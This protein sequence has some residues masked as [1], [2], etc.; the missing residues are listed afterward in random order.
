MSVSVGIHDGRTK[1]IDSFLDLKKSVC[2]GTKDAEQTLQI[3]D[4]IFQGREFNDKLNEYLEE[5]KNFS[6]CRYVI[7]TL[8]ERIFYSGSEEV[9]KQLYW[10]IETAPV[11]SE[12][13]E[14]LL[15]AL[16]DALMQKAEEIGTGELREELAAK[17]PK[18]VI[19][20]N[21]LELQEDF[22]FDFFAPVLELD[23]DEINVFLVRVLK[24][25]QLCG[26]VPRE[27]LLELAVKVSQ[28]LHVSETAEVLFELKKYYSSI[29][30]KA[31]EEELPADNGTRYIA[32]KT[33]AGIQELSAKGSEFKISD[34]P[35]IQRIIQWYK[36]L[37]R[38]SRRDREKAY[39]T[40]FSRMFGVYR[41]EIKDYRKLLKAEEIKVK[42][43]ESLSIPITIQY[44]KARTRDETKIKKETEFYGKRCRFLIPKDIELPQEDY[45]QIYIHVLPLPEN[46]KYPK[47]KSKW[48]PKEAELQ[49]VSGNT[50]RDG[51]PV[52]K[53]VH[54]ANIKDIA[55]NLNSQKWTRP[56]WFADPEGKG[57]VVLDILYGEKLPEGLCFE[58]N[59]FRFI[60]SI[61][62]GD[63][64]T[65]YEREITVTAYL[66]VSS[67]QPEKV[68]RDN[69]NKT[70]TFEE[71]RSVTR[72]EPAMQC[73]RRISNG[74]NHLKAPQELFTPAFRLC[75]EKIEINVDEEMAK[76]PAWQLFSEYM[77]SDRDFDAVSGLDISLS[78]KI[79]L[80]IS[81]AASAWMKD[82]MVTGNSRWFSG[83]R[84]H[85]QRS[86]I[87]VLLFLIYIKENA[88][89]LR[90]EGRER[91]VRNF[92]SYVDRN[93]EKFRFDGLY[94]GYPLDCLLVFLLTVCNRPD[95][96]DALRVLCKEAVRR[97]DTDE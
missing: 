22:F 59:G 55:P 11:L 19:R 61:P 20:D 21:L 66:D 80:D 84:Q 16:C 74:K 97:E 91:F 92:R 72:M 45:R 85:R 77:Y 4:F 42:K 62:A 1:D 51:K 78:E 95:M 7:K 65:R 52:V 32:E 23:L 25:D 40:L 41:T 89:V 88:E 28:K 2:K 79:G 30:S 49:I 58:Y 76:M 56:L 8:C 69:V 57:F 35:E 38:P 12:E 68:L 47:P 90:T 70:F 82:A 36:G 13:S 31:A 17:Y 14:E 24:R 15:S 10:E 37:E 53:N 96:G 6:T 87:L 5:W 3:D 27:Y 73:I 71:S 44:D 93:M 67:I 9:L 75:E 54:T 83:L 43:K 34:Y 18:D 39:E 46:K 86:V 63:E 29:D 81:T 94:L 26:Y 64:D 33:G 48:V 60:P 50:E